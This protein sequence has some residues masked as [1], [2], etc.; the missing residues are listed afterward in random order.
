MLILKNVELSDSGIYECFIENKAG[1]KELVSFK[2]LKVVDN[3]DYSLKTTIRDKKLT[4]FKNKN[5]TEQI[6][7]IESNNKITDHE[8][9]VLRW[10]D[11]NGKV[12]LL[13]N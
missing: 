4:F 8:S 13:K 3:D 9:L 2:K 1:I 5:S 10:F 7:S 6:C 12:V 11:K